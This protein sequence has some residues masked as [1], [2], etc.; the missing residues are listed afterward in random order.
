M[1]AKNTAYLIGRYPILYQGHEW[2]LTQNLM[3]FGFECGDGWFKIIDQ[4][5]ADITALDKRDGTTTI[6]TQVKEKFGGL[7]FYIQSGSDAVF[8]LIDEAEAL[9]E[10]T[11]EMCGEPGKLRGK[12]WVSTLCDSCWGTKLDEVKK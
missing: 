4:L 2:P 9:S 8:A 11:C 7:R 12:G 3:A 5:S 6:A 1:N 10:R